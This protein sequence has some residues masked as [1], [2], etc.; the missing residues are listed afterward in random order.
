MFVTRN[1]S[2]QNPRSVLQKKGKL[3]VLVG[4]VTSLRI[5]SFAFEVLGIGLGWL[6]VRCQAVWMMDARWSVGWLPGG[7]V[8]S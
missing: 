6:S 5:I 3:R 1:T 8:T 7:L 2:R 4:K